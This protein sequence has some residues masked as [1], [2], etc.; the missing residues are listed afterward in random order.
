MVR[1]SSPPAVSRQT[2]SS[3]AA[4]AHL[5]FDRNLHLPAALVMKTT[6]IWAGGSAATSAASDARSI[7]R[8]SARAHAVISLSRALSFAKAAETTSGAAPL[9][10]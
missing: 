1:I 9:N 7:R 4:E 5:L 3:S 8:N 2:M 6:E 10:S